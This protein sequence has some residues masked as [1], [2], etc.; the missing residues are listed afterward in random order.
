MVHNDGAMRALLFA[1]SFSLSGIAVSGRSVDSSVGSSSCASTGVAF[2]HTSGGSED[3]RVSTPS[4]D[5]SAI[6]ASAGWRACR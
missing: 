3:R 1:S 4:S 5:H 2:L 6:R